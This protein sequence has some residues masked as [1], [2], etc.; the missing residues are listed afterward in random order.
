VPGFSG[1]G[2]SLTIELTRI[3][4]IGV[5]FIALSGSLLAVYHA[6]QCFFWAELASLLGMLISFGVLIWAL[7]TFGVVAAA[8]VNV[9]RVVLQALLL[10]PVLGSYRRPVLKSA[11]M[12]EAWGRMKPLLLGATYYKTD[13]LVDRFLSSMAPAGSLS[14]FYIG[15]QLYGSA[16]QIINKAVVGPIVPILTHHAKNNSWEMFRRL[17]R[18]RL[19]WMA[20]LTMGGY[21]VFLVV[22]DPVLHLLI[23]YGALIEENVRQLWWIMLALG[24]VFIGGVM[25]QIT[26]VAFYAKHDTWTPTRLGIW[27][28]SVSIP[29]KVAAFLSFG[30]TGL[31][32]ST[33]LF[34]LTNLLLQFSHL[35]RFVLP[36]TVHKHEAERRFYI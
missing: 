9:L 25:G 7:P 21:C 15:Q 1:E 23:G 13:L 2:K 6:R 20:C 34:F 35:E 8:W 31:A 33:S 17:Y 28:Y 29:I 19:L 32:I 14:L 3:Q 12:T 30:L 26:S 11:K 27:T 16:S 36:F 5:V 18:Q 22:G 4:L 24:G 10:L